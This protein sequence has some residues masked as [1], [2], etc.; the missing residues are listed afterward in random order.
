MGNYMVWVVPSN[1]KLIDRATRY[2]QNLT[3]FSYESAN[4]LLFEVIE[5]VEPRMKADQAYPPVV[6]VAVIRARGQLSNEQAERRLR[7]ELS[8]SSPPSGEE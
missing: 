8:P 1:L 4:R 3:G 7:E 6:G 2:V 5:Y